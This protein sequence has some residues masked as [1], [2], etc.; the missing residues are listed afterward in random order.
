MVFSKIKLE[1]KNLI[2]TSVLQV[3]VKKKELNIGLL[4]ILGVHI[5]EKREISD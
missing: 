3:G 2:T 5:G 4:E 1:E